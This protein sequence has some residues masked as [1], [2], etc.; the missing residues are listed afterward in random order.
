MASAI[1]YTGVALMLLAANG[2]GGAI[3][4]FVGVAMLGASVGYRVAVS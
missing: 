4:W 1:T 3:G 2:I